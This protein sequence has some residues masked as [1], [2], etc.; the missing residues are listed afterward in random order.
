[1]KGWGL[2]LALLSAGAGTAAAQGTSTEGQFWPALVVRHQLASPLSAQ[3]YSQ[4]K[5]GVDYDYDQL[6][7]GVR[8]GYQAGAIR[9]E[10][11]IGI[12]PDAE[13]ALVLGTGYEYLDTRQA[14][15]D[16]YENRLVADGTFRNRPAKT[17][18]LADRNRFEFRWVDGVYSTRYRNRLT[19]QADLTAGD[20]RLS[21]YAS[22]E[23]FYDWAKDSWNE[24]QYA[25]GV[26][27]QARRRA[28][29][30]LYYL[31]QDCST[32]SP[33]YVNALGVT[34]TLYTGVEHRR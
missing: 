31:Y 13:H 12:D 25:L 5:S 20:V 17:W 10:H 18:L 23:F 27:W 34:L 21:P 19:V 3:L 8:L 7:L 11:L 6:G 16:K 9:K 26:L 1:M 2:A 14:S 33:Q 15:G 30:A 22:A 4:L 29:V 24:E 28:S 32:C